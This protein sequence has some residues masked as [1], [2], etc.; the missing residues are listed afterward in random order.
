MFRKLFRHEISVHE[1]KSLDERD[2][3]S[4]LPGSKFSP[5]LKNVTDLDAERFWPK[6]INV[7]NSWRW[8]NWCR[9]NLSC[10]KLEKLHGTV[11]EYIYLV[12]T[13][14]IVRF[15][16][17]LYTNFWQTCPEQSS[18]LSSGQSVQRRHYQ[19]YQTQG[20]GLSRHLSFIS[21]IP[22]QMLFWFICLCLILSFLSHRCHRYQCFLGLF[23]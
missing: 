2:C 20:S 13:R 18:P 11:T 19:N 15:W 9:T 16:A 4:S 7:T 3:S 5:L 23:F 8:Q 21:L 6:A 22:D 14:P 12:T 10:H 1:K 17:L